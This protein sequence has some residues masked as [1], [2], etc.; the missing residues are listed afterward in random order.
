MVIA[1]VGMDDSS[2]KSRRKRVNFYNTRKESEEP[3]KEPEKG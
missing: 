2:R 3:T 1:T